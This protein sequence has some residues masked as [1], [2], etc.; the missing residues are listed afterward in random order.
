MSSIDF[1]QRFAFLFSFLL[2]HLRFPWL[3]NSQSEISRKHADP[4]TGSQLAGFG[5]CA[6][7]LAWV[8]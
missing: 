5:Y 1:D 6:A 3:E 4:N 8:R 7:I 2:L